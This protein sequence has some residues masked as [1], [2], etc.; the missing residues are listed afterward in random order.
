MVLSDMA[1]WDDSKMAWRL[2]ALVWGTGL[3]WDNVKDH[4]VLCCLDGS[5]MV[6]SD[7]V[8]WDDSKMAWRLA[9]LVWGTGLLWDKS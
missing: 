2:A 1:D 7:K 4:N 8:D 3:L 5:V 6:L 9:A